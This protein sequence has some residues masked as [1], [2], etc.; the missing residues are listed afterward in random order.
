VRSTPPRTSDFVIAADYRS[1]ADAAAGSLA[2]FWL[3]V[4]ES[5]RKVAGIADFSADIAE[6]ALPENSIIYALGGALTRLEASIFSRFRVRWLLDSPANTECLTEFHVARLD[7]LHSPFLPSELEMPVALT[8]QAFGAALAK[9]LFLRSMPHDI[10]SVC[11]GLD[12]KSPW[13]RPFRT[14][15]FYLDFIEVAGPAKLVIW[16]G[17]F[18]RAKPTAADL[19]SAAAATMFMGAPL[20]HWVFPP[21]LDQLP[22]GRLQLLETGGRIPIPCKT[23]REG[24]Q[25]ALCRARASKAKNATSAT[26]QAC[27]PASD[28]C[29]IRHEAEFPGGKAFISLQLTPVAIGRGLGLWFE[30]PPEDEDSATVVVSRDADPWTNWLPPAAEYTAA[31]MAGIAASS[32]SARTRIITGSFEESLCNWEQGRCSIAVLARDFVLSN[33]WR[34]L[35]FAP[36]LRARLQVESPQTPGAFLSNT[37]ACLPLR[38]LYVRRGVRA[39]TIAEFGLDLL[40]DATDDLSTEIMRLLTRALRGDATSFDSDYRC[41]RSRFGRRYELTA[42][43]LAWISNLSWRNAAPIV[44]DD[45][46]PGE[47]ALSSALALASE[48]RWPEARGLIEFVSATSPHFFLQAKGTGRFNKHLL[49]AAVCRAWGAEKLRARAVDWARCTDIT[50][51]DQT[52]ILD[53]PTPERPAVTPP[54][55][56]F[57]FP[58]DAG[59]PNSTCA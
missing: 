30:L 17:H 45:T 22:V 35:P 39:R 40:D 42:Q 5:M 23:M 53:R 54:L 59:Q 49:W 1:A 41:A 14:P 50:F 24:T 47:L 32:H 36:E 58:W 25:L 2:W 55:P 46:V 13:G 29:T 44:G 8:P 16:L 33:A 7:R 43:V 20:G 19:V 37:F 48:S 34:N 6:R 52:F 56:H 51:H 12:G 57:S 4:I 15:A 31:A 10:D 3:P 21:P 28:S 38:E 11:R 26:G 27:T 18:Y 9:T